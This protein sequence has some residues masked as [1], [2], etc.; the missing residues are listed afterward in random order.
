[1]QP[2]AVARYGFRIRTRLGLVVDPV[3]I[4]GRDE[5]DAERKVRQIYRGCEIIGRSAQGADG[6]SFEEIASRIAR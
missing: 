5:A 1:M 2:P 6:M 4:P 3:V